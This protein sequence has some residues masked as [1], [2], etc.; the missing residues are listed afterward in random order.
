MSTRLQNGCFILQFFFPETFAKTG[1]VLAG[2]EISSKAVIDYPKVIRDTI[3][4]IG[5]DDSSKGLNIR[6]II[7]GC[8][9]L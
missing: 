2:G 6:L 7:E 8:N 3:K 1:L 5:Y 9:L 4:R